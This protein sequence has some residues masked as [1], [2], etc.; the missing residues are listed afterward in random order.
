MFVYFSCKIEMSY[1]QTESEDEAKFKDPSFPSDL[2][3]SIKHQYVEKQKESDVELISEDDKTFNSQR[4]ILAATSDYF[5]SLFK[6]NQDEDKAITLRNVSSEMLTIIISYCYSG[7]AV[8]TRDNVESLLLATDYCQIISLRS[9]CIQFITS[10]LDSDNSL[11][12]TLLA[13]SLSLDTLFTAAADHT[14]QH[15]SLMTRDV[16][17]KLP[18][19]VMTSLLSSPQ[20]IIRDSN[21]N[22]A[23]SPADREVYLAELLADY[24]H[25]NK[26]TALKN[27][28]E[29]VLSLHLPILVQGEVPAKLNQ[30][31]EEHC[32]AKLKKLIT[33]FKS[34]K[35]EA[36]LKAQI[37]RAKIIPPSWKQQRAYSRVVIKTFTFE[38]D[39]PYRY[40]HDDADKEISQFSKVVTDS[41]V[42]IRGVTVCLKGQEYE[43]DD[44]DTWDISDTVVSGLI[45]NWSN[46]EEDKFGG[47]DTEEQHKI[48]VEAGEHIHSVDVGYYN[49]HVTGLE[50]K[51]STCRS[52]GDSIGKFYEDIDTDVKFKDKHRSLCGFSGTV[53][54]YRQGILCSAKFPQPYPVIGEL[55]LYYRCLVPCKPNVSMKKI[56]EPTFKRYELEHAKEFSM[57]YRRKADE[58]DNMSGAELDDMLHAGYKEGQ[59]KQYRKDTREYYHG[60]PSQRRRSKRMRMCFEDEDSSEGYRDDDGEDGSDDSEDYRV[61]GCSIM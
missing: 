32:G 18:V 6:H 15:L 5:K 58:D 61:T 7:E 26:E 40:T 2:V 30:L 60:T 59:V 39:T 43:K 55:T 49:Q 35:P 9:A 23:L 28:E 10:H 29:L 24:V 38:H 20:V 52:F 50:F 56:L 54:N 1:N 47:V 57:W 13:D 51:S 36:P 41:S 53:V 14:T 46:G 16:L 45:V 11:N 44:T 3:E 19:N 27:F 4:L 25:L 31:I 42:D 48:D 17:M 22:L 21:S 37:G 8:I 33:K 12:V 34:I